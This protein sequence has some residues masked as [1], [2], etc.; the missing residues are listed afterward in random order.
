MPQ[1][2]PL[3]DIDVGAPTRIPAAKV[4][5]NRTISEVALPAVRLNLCSWVPD[6]ASRWRAFLQ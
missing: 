5:S 1:M 2:R 4:A 6:S 3:W